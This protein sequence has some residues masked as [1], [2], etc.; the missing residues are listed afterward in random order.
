MNAT[1]GEIAL[2]KN[3][4]EGVN[5]TAQIVDWEKG[6]VVV[7]CDCDFPTNVYPFLNLKNK[8]VNVSYV[9]CKEGRVSTEDLAEAINNNKTKLLSI[10]HVFYNLGHR[11]NLEEIGK[12]CMETDT[13]LHVDAAQ[14][15]GAFPIDV[16]DGIDFLSV[17]GFKWLLSP[18]GTGIYFVKNE[19]LDKEPPVVGW[20]SVKDNKQLDT[21]NYELLDTAKRLEAGTINI[22]GFLGMRAA[23]R[24]IDSI[25]LRAIQRRILELTRMLG[26]ELEGAGL[27]VLSD[28]EDEH[29]SGIICIEKKMVTSDFL[30]ENKIVATIRDNLRL[31]PHIYNNEEDIS[32]VA[33]ALSSL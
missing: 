1:P 20:L 23:L 13:L 26:E 15:L 14:S 33:S 8:G 21:R 27:K 17:P 19:H 16:M 2:T 28:L 11:V 29:R 12:I 6:D 3:T 7:V 22:G 24:L 30:R 10:S 32:K 25:G 9:N 31:S 4:T 18:I 5:L